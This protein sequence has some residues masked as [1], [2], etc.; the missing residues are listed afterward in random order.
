[1]LARQRRLRLP[2]DISKVYARG[3]FGVAGSIQAK[4]LGNHFGNIRVA[5]VVSRKISKKAVIRNRIRRRITAVC[6]EMWEN[7]TPG[8]D[9]VVT[10][11]QDVSELPAAELAQALKTAFARCGVLGGK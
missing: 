1:M 7:L 2:R 4:A 11:R 9:I 3:R 5:V 10:V 6:A 8:Y